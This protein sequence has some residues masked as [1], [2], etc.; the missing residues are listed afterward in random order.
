MLNMKV[1]EFDAGKCAPNCL[2]FHACNLGKE[3]QWS[4]V[5]YIRSKSKTTT[6]TATT[7]AMRNH[8][9]VFFGTGFL[10]T[11]KRERKKGEKKS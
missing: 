1:D 4:V 5:S 11:S 9:L 10:M 2:N 3:R 8:S 7:T 6:I